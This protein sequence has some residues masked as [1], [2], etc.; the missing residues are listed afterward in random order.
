MTEPTDHDWLFHFFSNNEEE[1]KR[2]G[3]QSSLTKEDF[4]AI[5]I[6]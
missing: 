5:L 4:E 1:T 2:F 3:I 6:L